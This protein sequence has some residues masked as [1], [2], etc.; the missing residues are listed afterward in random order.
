MVYGSLVTCELLVGGEDVAE[1]D[2]FFGE[3]LYMNMLRRLEPS[4]L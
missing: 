1:L 3:K 2:L 4:P